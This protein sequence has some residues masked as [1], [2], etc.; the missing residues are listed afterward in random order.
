MLDCIIVDDS[1]LARSAM[2]HLVE[3]VEFLN[4][5]HDCEKPLDAFNYLKNEKIDLVF[6][7]VEMPEMNGLE[8]IRSLEKRPIIIFVSAKK[9][10]AIEAFELNVA[11]YIIKP[12][13]LPRFIKAVN[14]AKELFES[15]GEKVEV[16][17]NELEFIFVKSKSIITKIRIQDIFHL[18]AL[19]DYVNIYTTEKMYTV[20]IT[21]SGIEKKLP[22]KKFYRLHRSYIIALD[23]I[24]H[25]EGETL[26]VNHQAIPIGEQYK[27]AL[28]KKINYI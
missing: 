28:L 3:Q 18:Q 12:V 14:R 23:K 15:K 19:G 25:I 1:Q 9:E 20:H 2:K 17:E 21:L 4:L 13:T 16:P 24:H 8:L 22:P 27:Q 7:D 5:K 10:Y 6:L 26:Y 11:D